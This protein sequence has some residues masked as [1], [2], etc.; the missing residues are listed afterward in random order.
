VQGMEK[1]ADGGA[2]PHEPLHP[3]QLFAKS[4]GLM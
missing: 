2:V 4:Y 1:L 3:I